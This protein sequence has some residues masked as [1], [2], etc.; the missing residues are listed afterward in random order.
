[1]VKRRF[2]M[3]KKEIVNLPLRAIVKHGPAPGPGLQ[4]QMTQ[5]EPDQSEI[6]RKPLLLSAVQNPKALHRCKAAFGG[7]G[8]RTKGGVLTVKRFP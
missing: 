8:P 6:Q 4:G 3:V 5:A 1:M 7:R 2:F